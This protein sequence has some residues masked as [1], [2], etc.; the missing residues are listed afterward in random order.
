MDSSE[1]LNALADSLGFEVIGP[2]EKKILKWGWLELEKKRI[3]K[4]ARLAL[5]EIG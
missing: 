5:E 4:E 1:P 2:D 3:N